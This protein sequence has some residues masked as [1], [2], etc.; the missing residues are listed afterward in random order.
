MPNRVS[1]A[2]A[3]AGNGDK[4]LLEVFDDGTVILSHSDRE[5]RVL[6]RT[7]S[8]TCGGRRVGPIDC[9]KPQSPTLDCTKN[10]PTITCS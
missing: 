5:G 3:A 10:P 4:V 1:V 9:P 6:T 8:G 7:C 2:T